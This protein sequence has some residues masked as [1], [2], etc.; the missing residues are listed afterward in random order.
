MQKNSKFLM[1]GVI[2]V[3]FLAE[4]DW[5]VDVRNPCI[6]SL[7]EV[8]ARGLLHCNVAVERLF[9]H[10]VKMYVPLVERSTP[11]LERLMTA[12]MTQRH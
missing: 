9:G 6:R 2:P 7:L 3:E 1:W 5:V 12:F 10:R 8:T 4:G 11:L